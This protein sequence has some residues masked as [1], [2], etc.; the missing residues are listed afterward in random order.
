[1][2]KE[3]GAQ[4]L[5][6]M[7]VQPLAA[8]LRSV[9]REEEALLSGGSRVGGAETEG[10]GKRYQDQQRRDESALGGKGQAGSGARFGT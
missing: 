6:T 3:P 7:V 4:W 9:G 1:M 5:R 2:I 8:D 10:R